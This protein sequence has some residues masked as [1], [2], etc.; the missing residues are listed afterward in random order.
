[1]KDGTNC[2]LRL[3]QT[4]IDLDWSVNYWGY[5]LWPRSSTSSFF[6]FHLK[7]TFE[8]ATPPRGHLIPAYY[9]LCDLCVPLIIHPKEFKCSLS[10]FGKLHFPNGLPAPKFFLGAGKCLLLSSIKFLSKAVGRIQSVAKAW[11][12]LA[13]GCSLLSARIANLLS[14]CEI[15]HQTLLHLAGIPPFLLACRPQPR[16]QPQRETTSVG[17]WIFHGVFLTWNIL[18]AGR[19]RQ[20]AAWAGMLSSATRRHAVRRSAT[21]PSSTLLSGGGGWWGEGVAQ[22]HV[23]SYEDVHKYINARNFLRVRLC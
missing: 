12:A 15:I 11:K 5:R 3:Q 17:W 20:K 21:W 14:E 4:P 1:M 23:N 19:S 18:L 7:F 16:A 2:D 10:P 22:E 6:F 13:Q 8:S 9:R